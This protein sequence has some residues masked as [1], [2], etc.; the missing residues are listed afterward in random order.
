M[1]SAKEFFPADPLFEDLLLEFILLLLLKLAFEDLLEPEF[2]GAFLP[3]IVAGFDPL[4]LPALS[5]N[6]DL[7]TFEKNVESFGIQGK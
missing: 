7:A 1:L 2:E 6:E 5:E 3:L 4:S